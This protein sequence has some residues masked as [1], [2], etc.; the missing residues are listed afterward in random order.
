VI[1][2]TVE[3]ALEIMHREPERVAKLQANGAYFRKYA[4]TKGLDTGLG[5]GLAVAPI[6]VGDSI[7]TVMLSQDLF[8]RGV[9]A[10]P[11]LYPAVPVKTS[12]LRYFLT[13]MHT[14]QDIENAIDTT[15]EA[16]ATLPERVRALKITG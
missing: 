4:R 8:E 1:A 9:N 16:M 14:E 5:Q 3:K 2:A 11:V 13:A 10:L 12:R 7:A 6:I 15:V